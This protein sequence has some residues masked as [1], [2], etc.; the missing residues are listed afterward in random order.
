MAQLLLLSDTNS[1]RNICTSPYLTQ[2]AHAATEAILCQDGSVA[3]WSTM[4]KKPVKAIKHAH[5]I[6][7]PQPY[8]HP[9]LCSAG[10]GQGLGLGN[11]GTARRW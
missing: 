8:A 3:L 2:Y 4:K 10:K 11:W 5:G 7:H 1:T 9:P 6:P